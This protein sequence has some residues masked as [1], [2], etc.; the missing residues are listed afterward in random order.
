MRLF[1]LWLIA[2]SIDVFGL[3]VINY[4]HYAW[5]KRQAKRGRSRIPE[6][7]LHLFAL[8]GGWPGGLLGQWMLR[9]KSAKIAFQ[10]M[11]WITAI[12]HVAWASG[13]TVLL[14]LYAS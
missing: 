5:D 7:R 14:Y 4:L 12:G 10:V 9:H 8:L 6:K 13:V 11:F 2:L 3:S 1:E